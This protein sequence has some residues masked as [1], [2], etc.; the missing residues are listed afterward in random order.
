[1]PLLQPVSESVVIAASAEAVYRCISDPTQFGRWSEENVG[2]TVVGDWAQGARVGMQFDGHNKWNP[3]LRGRWFPIR[4]W[5]TRCEV[6]AADEGRYFAF[7]ASLPVL[8]DRGKP[9]LTMRLAL[10]E[11]R[12]EEVAE[13]TKVTET[14]TPEISERLIRLSRPLERHLLA[15]GVTVETFQARNMAWML[16]RLKQDLESTTA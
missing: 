12:L 8:G 15:D 14:W 4:R 13:G 10:W 9:R 16:A 2:A 1:M 11:Y 5:T 3:K 7:R 6:I